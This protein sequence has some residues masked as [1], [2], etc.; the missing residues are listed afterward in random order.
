MPSPSCGVSVTDV[1][2]HPGYNKNQHCTFEQQDG[3][4]DYSF[5]HT[6][7]YCGKPQPRFCGCPFDYGGNPPDQQEDIGTVR[8][9]GDSWGAPIND[10]RTWV[11]TPTNELCAECMKWIESDDSGI[12]IPGVEASGYVSFHKK[13]FFHTIGVPGG[14]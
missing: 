9:F 8:W 6:A 13:C 12:R 5:S 7:G 3:V 1:R 10:P 14:W 2:S 4:H 11:E